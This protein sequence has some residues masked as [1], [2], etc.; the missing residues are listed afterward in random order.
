[1]KK[2]ILDEKLNDS[3]LIVDKDFE[4][5]LKNKLFNQGGNLMAQQ[6]KQLN[7][8][9]LLKQHHF[10]YASGAAL[11]VMA[12]VGFYAYDN[13]QENLARKT[14]IEDTIELP[15]QL[16]GVIGVDQMQTLAAV[17]APAGTTVTGVEIENEHGSVLYKVKFSDGSYRLYD[18]VTGLP[19]VGREDE[20]VEMDESIPA[21]FVA[22][23][24]LQQARDIAAA[25][26]PGKTI[27]KIEFDVEEGKV[28]YSVRFSDDGRVDV[29]ASDGSV[30]RVKNP[31][32]KNAEESDDE[33]KDSDDSVDSEDHAE[34]DTE[35]D[36]DQSGSNDQEDDSDNSGSG[37]DDSVDDKNDDSRR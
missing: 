1:M 19:Y 29:N 3:N 32:S 8:K 25:Q 4:F 31:E 10:L 7:M 24:S 28:V 33:N 22:G 12:A 20:A 23:I 14:I 5:K 27:T 35:D 11:V 36:G 17:D 15:A 37:S 16:D 9:Q 2:T 21:G 30:V 13:R 6:H 26:R 34:E 18:A